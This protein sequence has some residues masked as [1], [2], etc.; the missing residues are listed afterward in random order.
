ML[1]KGLEI[2]TS[3]ACWLFFNAEIHFFTR[4]RIYKNWVNMKEQL[5]E[6]ICNVHTSNFLV[7]L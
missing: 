3:G 4:N 7:L 1:V 6:K 5:E 2:F